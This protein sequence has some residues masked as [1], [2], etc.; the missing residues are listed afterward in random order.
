ME[1]RS[2]VAFASHRT[3]PAPYGK[4][5]PSMPLLERARREL[6][7]FFGLVR[8]LR[9]V[10]PVVADPARTADVLIENLADRYGDKTALI[11]T[12]ET[13]TYRQLNAR[14]NLYARWALAQGFGKG[15]AIA[16]LMPNR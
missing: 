13:L 16:L 9:A 15:D 11:S 1:R 2:G 3:K 7:Y 14:A 12:R 6:R 4:E 8:I 10:R 5:M